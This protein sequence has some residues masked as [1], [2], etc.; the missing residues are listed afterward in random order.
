M[1]TLRAVRPTLY[2]SILV[3]ALV[4]AYAFK[5]RTQG[6]FACPASGYSA[7]GYLG[8]CNATAYGEYDH[9]AFW[10]GL[11]PAAAGD[12]AAADVLFIGNSRME[13]GFSADAT[14]RWFTGRG[15]RH[16]L[17]GFTFLENETFT[18]PLLAQM[19]PRARVYVI[20]VDQFFTD[21]ETRPG[22][23]L[24]HGAESRERVA[25]KRRWQ[26]VHAPLCGRLPHLC[27]NHIAFYRLP[28]NGHWLARGSTPEEPETV[29]DEAP[30]DQAR[31]QHYAD[32]ARRFVSALPVPRDCVVLTI[33]PSP[34]TRRAEAGAIAAALDLPLVAPRVEGLRTFDDTH[35]DASSAERW[36]AAFLDAAGPRIGQCLGVPSTTAVANAA[37]GGTAFR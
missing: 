23:E 29:A 3:A 14:E 11:E 37:S 27:G 20:D 26:R 36:S 9:G 13:F 28:H 7:A 24:L 15:V 33:V 8:Y 12:A 16:Y 30:S 6:I 17:M 18:A 34:T 35:L 5:L 10:Y 22:A 21:E 2:V 31:W 32:M 19:K 4:G 25:E 1:S